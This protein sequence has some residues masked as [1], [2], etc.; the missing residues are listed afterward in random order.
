MKVGTRARVGL[1]L[2]VVVVA[3]VIG[4]VIGGGGYLAP[5]PG[6]TDA[7]PLVSW[8]LPIVRA[9]ALAAGVATC[10]WLLYAAFLGSQKPGGLLGAGGRDDVRRASTAALV[11]AVASWVTGILTLA[12]VLGTPLAETLNPSVVATYA[13][14]VTSVRA[15]TLGGL[16][17][18]GVWVGVRRVETLAGAAGW[19]VLAAGAMALVPLSGHAAGL[20][21]HG[22]ALA[23]GV[24]H[25]LAATAWVGGLLALAVHAWR[26][27]P[28]VIQGARRFSGVALTSV[29]A[30]ALTGVGNAVTRMDGW[31]QLVSTDYGRLVLLKVIALLV[32]VVLAAL[33]RRRLLAVTG[34]PA[35][36]AR[37]GTGTERAGR[38]ARG[39]DTTAISRGR[40]T[41]LIGFELA[42][43]ALATGLAVALTR[44]P[45]PR[46]ITDAANLA[47]SLLGRPIPAAPDASSVIL[48]FSFEPVMLVASL[49]AAGLYVAGVMRVR[50]RGDKW[51]VG[52][53][54]SWLLGVG[55]IIWATNSGLGIYSQVSFSMHMLQHMA[56]AMIAPILLVLGTPITLA[57][58]AIA[59][60][61]HGRRGP[62]EWIV[63][64]IGSPVAKFVTHPLW[65]LFIFTIGLYGLYYTSLFGYLMGSHLGHVAMQVH[66]ILAG[67][68]FS[69]VV[70]GLDPA[71]RTL[72]PWVR[73]GMVLIA[74]VLHSFFAVP[75]MMSDTAFAVEWYGQVQPPWITNPAADTR[76]AGG[77]AWGIAELPTLLLIVVLG[78]QW[79]RSDEREARRRDRRV[80]REG[81]LELDAYN[82]RLARM[83]DAAEHRRD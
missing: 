35:D 23:S 50:A 74:M 20:G 19:L 33:V 31:G 68:L 80:E 27:D 69:Y 70:L 59:P 56:L 52:R 18:L 47:E 12:N 54:I 1:L 21:S 38:S 9:I 65:V 6:I 72:P 40:I 48:G 58:R 76:T 55:A 57:L 17:A 78:V 15:F 60:A 66:F 5:A 28:G 25:T 14:D 30:L 61:P 73:L 8:S 46:P 81:D 79:A 44:T 7:G 34:E 62:R 42:V 83:N 53:L 36:G 51:P 3:V 63:W 10:G 49:V 71:P 16:I 22:L 41:A 29:A 32:L 77:I 75:I 24:V 45:Y 82:E 43:M 64:A 4:L 67:Y 2:A 13:W 26:N 37:G 39:E 11:W